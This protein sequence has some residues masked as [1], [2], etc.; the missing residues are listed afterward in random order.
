ME[1]YYKQ[2]QQ[3]HKAHAVLPHCVMY[4]HLIRPELAAITA[5]T[6]LKN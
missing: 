6:H 4:S 2:Q 5:Q 3:Q 1:Y